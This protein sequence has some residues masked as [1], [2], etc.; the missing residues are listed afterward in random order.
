MA[1]YNSLLVKAGGSLLSDLAKA[2]RWSEANLFIGL[3]GTGRDVVKNMKKQVSQ[4]LKPDDPDSPVPAY[5]NIRFL[6]VDSEDP[7]PSLC[8]F[9]LDRD[10]E[11]FDVSSQEG[12]RGSA[13]SRHAALLLTPA[14]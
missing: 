6:V 5:R 9:D 10:T 1:V 14:I 2:D 12:G 3:G 4:Y 7:G 8:P 13:M 11:F